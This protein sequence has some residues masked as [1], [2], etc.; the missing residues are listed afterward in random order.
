MFGACGGIGGGGGGG[1]GDKIDGGGNIGGSG[2]GGGG[3]GVDNDF[4]FFSSCSREI[5]FW[6][7]TKS[8]VSWHICEDTSL[9]IA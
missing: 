9:A 4:N 5:P 7:C 3:D 2:G 1:G 6:N 8:N